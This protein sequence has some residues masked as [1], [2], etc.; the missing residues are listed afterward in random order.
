MTRV[1][2]SA[3]LLPLLAIPPHGPAAATALRFASEREQ[4]PDA[5][6]EGPWDEA[7]PAIGS[8]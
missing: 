6:I 3:D 2:E 5:A 4:D 7:A 1:E 8:P